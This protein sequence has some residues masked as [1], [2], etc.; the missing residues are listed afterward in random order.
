MKLL[1]V[2]D[3]ISTERD[4]NLVFVSDTT[5]GKFWKI[6]EKCIGPN[7]KTRKHSFM[8]VLLSS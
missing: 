5:D 2:V 1:S 4:P 8:T 3:S 7:W 6:V